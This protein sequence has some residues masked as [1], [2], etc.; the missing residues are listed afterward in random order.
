VSGKGIPASLVMAVT[1][2][3]FR[4]VSAHETSPLRIVTLMNDS[5][6]ETNENNM[7]VTFF[8]GVLDLSSGH[9]RYCN[10]GHNAPVRMGD[11]LAE[12][13]DVIPNLPLG[14]KQGMRYQEQ[15]TDLA[16]GEGLFLY[17][18]GLTEAENMDHVLFGAEKMLKAV[19]R[20]GGEKAGAQLESMASEVKGHIR[21]CEPSDDL[22]M[23]IV[24]FTNPAP[25]SGSERHLILHNDIREI[26]QLAAFMETIAAETKMDSSLAMSMNLALEEAVSNVILYAYPQGSDGLVDIEAFIRE[27]R[28]DF[29]IT[30]SGVPFDPTS[31]ADPD[32]TLDVKDR[33]VGGL[34]IYLVKSIMDH[35][36]YA[37]EEG[38]NILSMT[39]K[40]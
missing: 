35:V 5:M 1:R 39:K 32:L 7:F 10:A 28:L 38:K 4:S 8:L 36:S 13:L 23:L 15:E 40:R 29:I 20:H 3:L 37:R 9:L 17:T 11:G 12:P 33:P 25:N 18:D 21:G 16:S 24:R 14:I 22:T 19:Y 2:S 30:D 27:D 26:P 34:G 6:S 31:V